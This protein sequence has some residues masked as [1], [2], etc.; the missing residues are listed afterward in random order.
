M[1][2]GL[3]LGRVLQ[4]SINVESINH[5]TVKTDSPGTLL[6]IIATIHVLI[7]WLLLAASFA[8]CRH[9]TDALAS[10]C[11][12]SLYIFGLKFSNSSPPH[13]SL[14]SGCCQRPLAWRSGTPHLSGRVALD[15]SRRICQTLGSLKA[16]ALGRIFE[17]EAPGACNGARPLLALADSCCKT[18]AGRE[19]APWHACLAVFSDSGAI[20]TSRSRPG[21]SASESCA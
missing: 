20:N 3:Q 4:D 21:S 16:S 11:V 17:T 12:G 6:A 15:F 1:S 18:Q 8:A 9:Y 13:Q 14:P 2:M 10:Y 7:C 19:L 5:I